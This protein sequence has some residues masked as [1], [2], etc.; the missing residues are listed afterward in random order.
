M[1]AF[2]AILILS[3]VGTLF[4]PWWILFIPA[5][6]FGVWM[7]ENG[8]AAFTIGFTGAGFAWFLQALYIHIANGAI[9]TTRIA[10]MMGVGSPWLI[11]VLTFLV[12]GLPGAIGALTGYLLKINLKKNPESA[13]A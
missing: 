10:E 6:F 12:G 7:I 1:R 3:W 8:F 4:L 5:F 9:V 13:A 2:L 11:L